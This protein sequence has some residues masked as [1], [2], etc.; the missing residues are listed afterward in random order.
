M[1]SC[2]TILR[3]FTRG[4]DPI[5]KSAK[6]SLGCGFDVSAAF[7]EPDQCVG[8]LRF[9]GLA[10]TGDVW[11]MTGRGV[12]CVE[13]DRDGAGRVLVWHVQSGAPDRPDWLVSEWVSAECLTPEVPRYLGARG[14]RG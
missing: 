6:V 13:V 3:I 7:H 2:P 4:L 11:R 8:L 14:G 5:N 12:I 9:W 10:M 1:P